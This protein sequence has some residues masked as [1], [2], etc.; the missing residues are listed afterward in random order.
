MDITREE[1]IRKLE[2]EI[3]GART[4]KQKC[5]LL[6]DLAMELL[7]SHPASSLEEAQK[8]LVIADEI[9]FLPGKAR[10]YFCIGLVHFNLSDYEKAFSFL[11]RA[12][13]IFLESGDKW[14]T[15]N[16]LN[17]MGLIFMRL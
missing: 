13:H 4:P 17:H 12:Y 2:S 3:T 16:A 11:D 14:G 7:H 9:N 6:I 10:S 1:K 8:A 15:S 5:N